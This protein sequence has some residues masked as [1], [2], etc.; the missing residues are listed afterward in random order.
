M[1]GTDKGKDAQ[2]AKIKD[3]IQENLRALYDE[4]LNE[5]I[6]DHL[7]KLLQDLEDRDQSA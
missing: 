2:S 5:E 6:P 3:Q 4:T 1:S 7:L